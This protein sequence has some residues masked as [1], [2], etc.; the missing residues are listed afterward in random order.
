MFLIWLVN[1]FNML[2]TWSKLSM[3]ILS[4]YCFLQSFNWLGVCPVA[5][6]FSEWKASFKCLATCYP[7][8]CQRFL[9]V[10]LSCGSDVS[11]QEQD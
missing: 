6:K 1:F 4:E 10:K 5:E 8:L 9:S 7:N 2:Q 11:R 3:D